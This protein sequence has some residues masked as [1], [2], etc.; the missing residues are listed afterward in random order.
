MVINISFEFPLLS[1]YCQAAFP[2][3][4][5]ES[6]LSTRFLTNLIIRHH[7]KRIFTNGDGRNESFLSPSLLIFLFSFQI[8]YPSI[9]TKSSP[10]I[11][12][13]SLYFLS[14]DSRWFLVVIICPTCLLSSNIPFQKL[15]FSSVALM[16]VC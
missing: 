1:P 15:L 9:V 8:L 6:S 10:W 2:L 5:A 11:L 13:H 4:A 14:F 12:N 7:L 3:G 16:C